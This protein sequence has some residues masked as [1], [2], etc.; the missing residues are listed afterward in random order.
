MD[1]KGQLQYIVNYFKVKPEKARPA[2]PQNDASNTVSD[3]LHHIHIGAEVAV[4]ALI[5]TVAGTPEQGFEHHA[6]H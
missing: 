5:F 4:G 3:F 1:F 6:A 2:M